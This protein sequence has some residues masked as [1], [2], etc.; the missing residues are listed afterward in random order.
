MLTCLEIEQPVHGIAMRESQLNYLYSIRNA[1]V[2]KIIPLLKPGCRV[3]E[4][5]GGAGWQAK[6]LAEAGFQVSSIDLQESLY[7]KHQV[8]KVQSY[9]GKIIPFDDDSFDVIFSSNVLE[10][11]PEVETF[12]TEISRVL[13]KDGKAI[14][15]LPT[16]VWR[17]WAS[18]SHYL[19][20]LEKFVIKSVALL[21]GNKSAKNTTETQPSETSNIQST[22]PRKS[23][24]RRL[25]APS[26]HGA[27]G[28]ALSEL[29][30][31]SRL[32]WRPL[33]R[34]SGWQLNAL[35]PV[36]L[37]YTPFL[38]TH[39]WPGLKAARLLSFLLGSSC[40]VYVLEQDD[41]KP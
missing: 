2:R 39:G 23:R 24:I 6:Q 20:L 8:W 16:S 10:H 5:G 30:L 18:V 22:A 3:L 26:P 25:L 31:F 1:E 38:S 36:R 7:N 28:S 9:D 21:S 4:I 15:I 13:K 17:F 33:F 12:Q 11:I 41:N 27:I 32:R 29:Y 14:H 37:F 35:S 40:L 19:L 34:R